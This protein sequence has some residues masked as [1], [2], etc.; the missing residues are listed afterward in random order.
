MGT[1]PGSASPFAAPT[2]RKGSGIDVDALQAT[3]CELGRV[4][5]L[6]QLGA[7]GPLVASA[8][9]ESLFHCLFG[10]DSLRMALDLLDDFPAL[11]RTTLLQLARLQGVRHNPRGEEE[12]GRILHEHRYPGDPHAARLGQHW[13]LPYYGAVD[14]TPQWIN[15]LAAY[16]ERVGDTRI[17]EEPITDRA[18]RRLT[19]LDS[20]LMALEWMLRR[21][22]DASGGGFIWV[23]RMRPDGIANQV[24]EDSADAYYHADGRL[25]D[26]TRAYAPV[27]VQG[28]AFDALLGASELLEGL[29]HG[30]LPVDT[31][32]LRQRASELR[33]RT[34]GHFWQPDLGTFA[35]AV[36]VEDGGLLRPARVVASSPGQLLATRLLDGSDVNPVRNRLAARLL[37]P[38]LLACAGI[39]TKSTSAARFRAGAYHNG[40]TWPW[41][42]G[43]IADGLRRH[44]FTAAATD[45]DARVLRACAQVGGFPEFFRGDE[46]DVASINEVIVDAIVDGVPNR[47]E[48]PPQ[49]RQ[50]WTA[51]RVWRI[52]RR[53]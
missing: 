10:R 11:A 45:L 39:R 41:D 35:H 15:L 8:G 14:T 2:L 52:L 16:C 34:L 21:L 1:N 6:E 20:L 29:A 9:V 17:L 51:T 47:L 42:T 46:S 3:L 44:G 18:W 32:N 38:D 31:R 28:L 13:D 7:S 36:S 43:V 23:R 12:P 22:D 25:L 19:L 33:A 49:A 48:Q 37:E 40:S 30:T 5:R 53:V 24:W 50:G 27:G 26:F 4:E